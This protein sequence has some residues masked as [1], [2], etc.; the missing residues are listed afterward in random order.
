M[1]FNIQNS[2]PFVEFDFGINV[3]K[4]LVEDFSA[5]GT[6][7][8][9]DA[10]ST[11]FE[12]VSSVGGVYSYPTTATTA[13]VTSSDTASDNTGTVLVSG[14]DENYDLASETLTI[15][16]GA[17]SITFIRV[18]SA[19]MLTANTGNANVGNLTV[20]VDSKTVAYVQATYGASLSAIYTI[21]RNKRG[22]IVSASIGMSKQKEVESKILTK[23]VSNGNVWNTVG[24][25]TT[26]AVPVY[27]K[28]EIPILVDQKS[29]IELRAKADATSA[30]SGSFSLYLEDYH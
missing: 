5:V 17:G 9:N 25:Q 13:T 30:I 1:A 19:R 6:F 8:Y 12:T 4:G 11:S 22:W 29:D 24:Y 27:R 18:F 2:K 28:F 20:T 3:Q 7:G 14:L 15:G 10:V 21:P 26:F 23:Q 16:G